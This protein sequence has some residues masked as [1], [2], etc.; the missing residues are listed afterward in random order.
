MFLVFPVPALIQTILISLIAL[1][2]LRAV[3]LRPYKLNEAIIALSRA[4]L[5]L[6]LGL[7]SPRV[8]FAT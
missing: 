8:A 4:G 7:L 5:I 3:M 2:T 6:I 1:L